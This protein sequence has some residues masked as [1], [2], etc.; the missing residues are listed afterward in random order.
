MAATTTTMT[1]TTTTTTMASVCLS[2]SKRQRKANYGDD[3]VRILLEE[4]MLARVV[5]FSALNNKIS[6]QEKNKAWDKVV[7]AINA[8]GVAKRCRTEIKEKW[9]TMKSEVLGR[10]RRAMQTGGGPPES[11]LPYEE[12]IH[13]I[14]G[15]ESN[16]YQGVMGKLI[17]NYIIM[18][19]VTFC[20]AVG[21][22]LSV[23]I[24]MHLFFCIL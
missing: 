23:D 18:A 13:Q 20:F 2:A 10:Q 8:C 7:A 17:N 22:L 5:L 24:N 14:I 6:L 9:K 1:T 19:C 11:A 21:R 12:I 4:V 16:L 15:Y 3:E